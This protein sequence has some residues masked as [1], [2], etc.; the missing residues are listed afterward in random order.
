MPARPNRSSSNHSKVAQDTS[1]NNHTHMR[2][3]LL[4]DRSHSTTKVNSHR[5]LAGGPTIY[6]PR[7]RSRLSL[8]RA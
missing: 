1:N 3:H 7:S 5:T 8:P 2:M 4:P 6:R